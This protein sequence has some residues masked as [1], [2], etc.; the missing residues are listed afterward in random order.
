M[1]NESGE[2]DIPSAKGRQLTGTTRCRV[3]SPWDIVMEQKRDET[4][5]T[6]S[7]SI[8]YRCMVGCRAM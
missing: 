6:A 8:A 5:V 7:L 2:T 3:A 4:S 1:G